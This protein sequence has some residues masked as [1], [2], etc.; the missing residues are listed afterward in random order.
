M[1]RRLCLIL[2]LLA[3]H[4]PLFAQDTGGALSEAEV[5]QLR[6]T[7]QA[8]PERVQN[9]I[10]FL[11]DRAKA[12]DTLFAHPR[13]PGREQYTHDLMEQFTSIANELD[14]NLSDYDSRHEDIRKALPKLLDATESW[15]TELKSPPDDET[16]NVS[17]KLALQA[18]GDLR[19]DANEM[20]TSQ[21]AW[22]AAH[23]PRKETKG[24]PS[25]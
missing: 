10:K 5:E 12:I 19:D 17:R 13:K 16:Y 7:A 9:Y 24:N 18:I 8:P 11:N 14:D 3:F 20:T 4:P 6:D 23:P 25:E 15:N 21:K 22:F 1:I 2:V